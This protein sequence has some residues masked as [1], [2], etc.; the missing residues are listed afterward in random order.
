MRGA[1]TPVLCAVALVA[2]TGIPPISGVLRTLWPALLGE[3]P[4]RLSAAF[5]LDAVLVEVGFVLGPA[6]TAA[7]V[8][9]ASPQAALIL[10]S[11][12]VV[13][14]T[15]GVV[16]SPAA[17][18]WR[19][20]APSPSTRRLIG[21]L[22]APGV[23]TI[24]LATLPIGVAF[25][26]VEVALPAFAEDEGNRSL[27][28]LLL[29]T[30]AAGSVLGGLWWG[31]R[32]SRRGLR[33]RY[34]RAAFGLPVGLAPLALAP[35]IPLMALGLLAAGVCI[36]PT[37]A[38][39]NQ[40][41]GTLA[42]AGVATEA[43]QWPTTALVVGIG[44]GNAASGALVEVGSWRL[45]LAVAAVTAVGGGGTLLVRRASLTAPA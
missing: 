11:A 10:G 13:V 33:E 2:G 1:P 6:M 24:V 27:A 44:V 34:L 18:A 5:A 30:W 37:L 25:G 41:V 3:D 12:M 9:W 4:R 7:V 42:P 43:F 35:S 15:L 26:A 14:G 40:L 8:L 16:G 17:R 19:R 38:A 36:A 45:S 21:A 32:T 39:A 22:A 23:R 31:A 29:G 28:G 20:P